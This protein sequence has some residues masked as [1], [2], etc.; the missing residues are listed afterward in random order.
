MYDDTLGKAGL[1]DDMSTKPAAAA[2][3]IG[4]S[5]ASGAARRGMHGG[6]LVIKGTLLQSY[7]STGGID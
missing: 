2:T 5:M 7:Y 3:W 1:V 4:F 6:E